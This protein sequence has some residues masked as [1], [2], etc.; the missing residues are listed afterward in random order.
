MVLYIMCFMFMDVKCKK[1]NLKNFEQI[2]KNVFSNL[3][4][5]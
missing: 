1:I 2:D 4:S 5:L 3:V